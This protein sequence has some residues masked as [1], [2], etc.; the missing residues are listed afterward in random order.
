VGVGRGFAVGVRVAEEV[1]VG[2]GAA[3][4]EGEVGMQLRGAMEA[5]AVGIE[6]LRV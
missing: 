2:Q 1:Q 6:A 3:V 5:E 4:V